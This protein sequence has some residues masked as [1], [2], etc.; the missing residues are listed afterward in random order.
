MEEKDTCSGF[1]WKKAFLDRCPVQV[2]GARI[3]Q[4]HWIP[5]E[6]LAEFNRHIA[7]QIEEI[8]SFTATAVD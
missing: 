8:G 2:A 5:S 1:A 3:H 6:G 7:G 4:E